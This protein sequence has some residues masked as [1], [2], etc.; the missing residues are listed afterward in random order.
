MLADLR[1]RGR[2]GERERERDIDGLPLIHAPTRDQTCKLGMC[3]DRELNPRH[4]G[5]WNDST[6][7]KATPARMRS[8]F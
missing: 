3:P 1:E 5:L 2:E 4:F 6:M 7:N 8:I